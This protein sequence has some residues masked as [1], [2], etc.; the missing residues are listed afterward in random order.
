MPE[1]EGEVTE[2]C[3]TAGRCCEGDASSAGGEGVDMGEEI[4]SGERERSRLSSVDGPMS[5][6]EVEWVN[7]AKVAKRFGAVRSVRRRDSSDKRQQR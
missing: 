3:M 7:E 6:E 2:C 1:V 5:G 4:D